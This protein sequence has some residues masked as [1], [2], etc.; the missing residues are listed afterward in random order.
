MK[1]RIAFPSFLS[2]LHVIVRCEAMKFEQWPIKIIAG[3][4]FAILLLG[5][6]MIFYPW[7]RD[8]LKI[9]LSGRN[10][11]V[12]WEINNSNPEIHSRAESISISRKCSDF[13]F[14]SRCF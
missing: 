14:I 12:E 9:Q 3:C 13:D 2:S 7:L 5:H 6:E 1:L 11:I 4:L 10:V 8:C